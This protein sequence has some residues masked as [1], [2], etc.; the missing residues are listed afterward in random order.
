MIVHTLKIGDRNF[1][2]V[3]G[4]IIPIDQIKCIKTEN[5]KNGGCNNSVQIIVEGYDDY[6]YIW[7]YDNADSI[8][9][10]L[11]KGELP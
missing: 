2:N 10:F 3:G 8:R 9:E 4:D 11:S 6:E 1:I 5:V 7:A